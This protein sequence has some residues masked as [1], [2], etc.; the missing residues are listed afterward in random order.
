MTDADTGAVP[1]F[2]KEIEVKRIMLHTALLAA[3]T[4]G[5]VF[6]QTAPP[7]TPGN[8]V[9]PATAVDRDGFL[10]MVV[11]SNN[12]EIQSSELAKKKT[13]REDIRKLAD[14]IIFDHVGAAVKLKARL[15]NRPQDAES[16]PAA[17]LAPKHRDMLDQLE[18]APSGPE[19]DALYLK[20]QG[21]AHM[22][23]IALFRNYVASGE[24]QQLVGFARETLPALE[25]HLARV[26]ELSKT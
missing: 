11:S 26:T 14:K 25:S 23:A 19:F 1:P 17:D 22:E 20:L 4:A 6:A 13:T 18:A 16:L 3:L 10:D 15:E 2:S 9:A 12:W 7:P 8:D 21:D 5:P 24:D